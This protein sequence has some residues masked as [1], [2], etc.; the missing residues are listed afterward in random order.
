MKNFEIASSIEL[1]SGGLNWDLHNFAN[2]CGLLLVPAENVVNMTWQ[3]PATQNPWGSRENKFV[4]MKLHFSGLQFL[5]VG[6]RD[7]HLPLTEDDCVS[8][9]LKVNPDLHHT[10]PYMRAVL[11]MTDHFRLAF[12]FQSRRMIEIGSDTVELL[13]LS[14][15]DV[16]KRDQQ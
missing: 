4:G 6:L 2:F 16:Y 10:D 1:F 8:D 13:P 12:C 7:E 3:V 5:H 14:A 9:I 15:E 11:E